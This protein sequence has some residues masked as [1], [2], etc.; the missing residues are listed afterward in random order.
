MKL[1][2]VKAYMRRTD[3]DVVAAVKDVLGIDVKR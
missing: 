2:E 3:V 1:F